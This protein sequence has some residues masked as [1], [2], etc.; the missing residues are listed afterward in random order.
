M[1]T[2]DRNSMAGVKSMVTSAGRPGMSGIMEVSDRRIFDPAR[3][4]RDLS[5][6]KKKW[7]QKK[8]LNDAKP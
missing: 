5:L 6:A 1:H 7:V 3:K 8:Q 4:T 2:A